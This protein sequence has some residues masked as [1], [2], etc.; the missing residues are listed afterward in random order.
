MPVSKIQPPYIKPG[1][2][3]A[4]VSPAFAIDREKIEDA[5]NLLEGWGLRVRIGKNALKRE[6]PFAGTEKERLSDF[7]EMTGNKNIKAIFCGRGGYGL[8]KIIDRIDFSSLKR[9]PKWYVG[10]SDITVLHAWLSEKCNLVSIHGEMPLNFS[11]PDKSPETLESLHNALFGGLEP[12][13]WHGEFIRPGIATGEVTGGNLSLLYSLIGTQAE[14]K[15]RGRIMF[16]ED[17]GEYYYHLDRMMTSLKLAGKLR[18]LAALVTGG[19]TKMEETK[20]P[21]GKSAGEIIGGIVAGYKYPVFTGFPAGHI[22]DN[23]A[24][25]IGRKAVIEIK[26]GKAVFTYL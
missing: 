5:V 21:W 13:R 7:Q 14:P 26:R 16:I 3:T 8:L 1:D 24:F 23:R 11:N 15:T 19:F 4:I 2:E 6:G 18:G 17:T 25:Y 12:V 22:D 20:I 9:H 10:F